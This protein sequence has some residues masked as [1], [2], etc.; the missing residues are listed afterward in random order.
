[1]ITMDNLMSFDKADLPQ[2]A[3]TLLPDEIRQLILWLQEKNDAIRY[4]AFLLLQFRS[5]NNSDVYPYW[6]IFMDKL[7]SDNSYQRSIGLMLIAE[8]ARWDNR[9]LLDESISR[10]LSYCDDEKPVTVRQCIQG[11]EKIVPFKTNLRGDITEKLISISIPDRKDT[12]RKVLLQDI[13]RV[14]ILINDREKNDRIDSYIVQAMTGDILD[15]KAKKEIAKL[16]ESI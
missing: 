5:E 6:D 14:L 10:Y 4:P 3:D 12:Q 16:M 7:S 8:N 15:K 2:I 11:L 9:G 1:M 13:L